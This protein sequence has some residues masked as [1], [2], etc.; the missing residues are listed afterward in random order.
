[1]I[2]TSLANNPILCISIL[3][4]VPEAFRWKEGKGQ[5]GES[6]YAADFKISNLKWYREIERIGMRLINLS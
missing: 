5:I 3:L 4:P 2:Y 6:G 1:V